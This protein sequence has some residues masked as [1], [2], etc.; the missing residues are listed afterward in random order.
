MEFHSGK[1][2]LEHWPG[3][4]DTEGACRVA[5]TDESVIVAPDSGGEYSLYYS[6]IDRVFEHDH[7]IELH[8]FGGSVLTV[9]FLGTWFGQCLADLRLKRGAQLVRNLGMLDAAFEKEFQ[10]AYEF[11]AP[12]GAR[13]GDRACRISLY[14]TSMVVE[15]AGGDFW[16]VA[17]ADIEAMTFDPGRYALDLRLDLGERISFRMLGTRFGEL[18]KELRRLSSEMYK[19]TAASLAETVPEAVASDLAVLL[20]QGKAVPQA[21][22]LT[23]APGFWPAFPPERQASLD[24]LRSLTDHIYVG[25]R[26]AFAGE[27][28]IYWYVAVFPEQGRLA[29]EVP[30]EEGNAT[31]VYRLDGPEE[32]SVGLLS[33]AMVALNFRREV[34]SASEAQ[35]ADGRMA[36]YRVAV[37]KL[38]YLRRLRELFVG[39]AS[40]TDGWQRRIGELVG[41]CS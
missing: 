17:Y 14:R 3:Q 41:I 12:D 35:L 36:R 7:R 25:Y 32:R 13:H 37:R 10:G 22:V 8:H 18:E 38:P 20:R 26:E 9:Y 33:R 5:L 30:S 28:P 15:P 24:Y 29:V 1:Y 34:I 27:Q 4:A 19:R 6:D 31:Y 21:R 11:E 23:L 16:S 39:K 40:H 2:R